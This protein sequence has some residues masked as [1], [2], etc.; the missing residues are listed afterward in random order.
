MYFKVQ[1]W[2]EKKFGEKPVPAYELNQSTVS[3]LHELMGW[4]ERKEADTQLVIQD[5]RQKADE[6]NAE[7]KNIIGADK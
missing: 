5:L 2:L 6:Y 4:N 3:I 1:V 7:G